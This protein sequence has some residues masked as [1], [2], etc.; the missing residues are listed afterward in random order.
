MI[1]GA[2][3]VYLHTRE[4]TVSLAE[5]TK[6]SDLALDP[7]TLPG[8]PL[9]EDAM[10]AAGFT[11]DE[12]DGQPGMWISSDG[13]PVD[14][15]V[16]EALAGRGG[17]RGARIPPHARHAA[18]R[19]TGL[20]A[21]VVDHQPMTIGALT[22]HDSRAYVVNVASPA[23][24]LVAKLHKLAD[25]EGELDRLADKDAHDIYRLLVA[26]PSAEFIAALNWL[27]DEPLA[28]RVTRQAL[29]NLARLFADGP[30]ALGSSMAGRAEY[31]IGDPDVVS[32]SAAALSQDL[33]AALQRPEEG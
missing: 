21:V 32:A 24:L 10:G 12:E 9:L 27:S 30:D 6:D 31:G 28:G 1:I 20:E 13:I 23:A 17:R 14:L 7:R 11:L 2:Q 16:P 8:Q 5:A 19:A 4:A 15:M 29:T 22:R 25:R 3:A 18:R 33:L 26:V